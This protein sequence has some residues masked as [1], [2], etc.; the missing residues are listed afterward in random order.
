MNSIH[1]NS[2]ENQLLVHINVIKTIVRTNT[3]IYIFYS[4]AASI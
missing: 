4:T 2:Y 1:F 3:A